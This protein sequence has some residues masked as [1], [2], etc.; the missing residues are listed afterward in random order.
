MGWS[1]YSS[2]LITGAGI[3]SMY[4]LTALGYYITYA[5]SRTVNFAQGASLMLG[6]VLSFTLMQSW[7]WPV[8]LAIVMTLFCCAVWGLAVEG[9][10]YSHFCGG[11]PIPG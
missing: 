10:G 8:S 9:S 2:A 4:G 7:H 6:A 3:G 5:I 11:D 1:E